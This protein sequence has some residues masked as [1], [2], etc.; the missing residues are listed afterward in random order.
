MIKECVVPG[1]GE[2]RIARKKYTALV[3]QGDLRCERRDGFP[4]DSFYH[5]SPGNVARQE[6]PVFR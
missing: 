2:S 1:D 6:S 5:A 4:A 3:V